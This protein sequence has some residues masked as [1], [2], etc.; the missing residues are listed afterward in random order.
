MWRCI[1]YCPFFVALCV[2]CLLSPQRHLHFIADFSMAM[3]AQLKHFYP[4]SI[5]LETALPKQGKTVSALPTDALQDS[6]QQQQQ[7]KCM[8]IP[9][10]HTQGTAR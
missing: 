8:Q 9:G 6:L 1:F 4:T 3:P 2:I 5:A 10:C 7:G